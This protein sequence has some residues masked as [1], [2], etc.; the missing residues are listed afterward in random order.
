[1]DIFK[2]LT[3]L[4]G[5]IVLLHAVRIGI[6]IAGAYRYAKASQAS[7]VVVRPI[8]RTEDDSEPS[9]FDT[10]QKARMQKYVEG[11]T[12]WEL[13]LAA[14]GSAYYGSL[15]AHGKPRQAV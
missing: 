6:E 2:V 3:A 5:L 1:M 7:V 15:R 12:S 14:D 8:D 11:L 9:T 10:E 13:Q 4:G